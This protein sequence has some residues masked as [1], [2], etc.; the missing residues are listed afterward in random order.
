M[1]EQ[2]A[3]QHPS[4]SNT[5]D[6][7]QLE[8][9]LWNHRE[10]TDLGQNS[11]QQIAQV[12]SWI[13]ALTVASEKA[14]PLVSD[15]F[16]I[17]IIIKWSQHISSFFMNWSLQEWFKCQAATRGGDYL[18]VSNKPFSYDLGRK[19]RV[20]DTNFLGNG[21]IVVQ[22]TKSFVRN[23]SCFAKQRGSIHK[24]VSVLWKNWVFFPSTFNLQ[25]SAR[26]Y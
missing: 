21:K 5:T 12:L 1:E 13:T 18:T 23:Y 15:I 24:Q 4:S 19:S 10:D 16:I 9:T 14:E 25:H 22:G 2:E 26:K 11:G 6:P 7:N 20:I 17:I 8:Y 3:A